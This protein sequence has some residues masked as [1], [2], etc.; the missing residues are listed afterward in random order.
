MSKVVNSCRACGLSLSSNQ[1]KYCGEKN[2]E[3]SCDT[4]GNS[5]LQ[6]CQKRESRFCSIG[7]QNKNTDVI[8][9]ANKS[10]EEADFQ[11]YAHEQWKKSFLAKHGVD[12][13]SQLEEV[14]AK[15]A[16]NGPTGFARPEF[17]EIIRNRYNVENVSQL[18]EI[19]EKIKRTSL[20]RYGTTNPASSAQVKEKIEALFLERYGVKSSLSLPHVQSFSANGKRISKLNRAWQSLILNELNIAMEF[21]EHFFGSYADLGYGNLLVDINPAISHSSDISYAHATGLCQDESCLVHP[22]LKKNYHQDRAL[23]A[24]SGGKVLISIFDSTSKEDA[25]ESIWKSHL[26][27]KGERENRPRS[28]SLSLDSRYLIGVAP[29]GFEII[30]PK[31]NAG[32]FDCG[33][34]RIKP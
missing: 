24:L 9:K 15:K 18:P 13:P 16:A 28:G 20:E 25:L 7:C 14:K 34:F 5:Y 11:S 22:P 27:L 30:E 21:E 26:A 29:D 19:R 8:A 12:N 4:C 31:E 2:L 6:K 32:V 17:K 1:R 3:K 23:R 33:E 10:R